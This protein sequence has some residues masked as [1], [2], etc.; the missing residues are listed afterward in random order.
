MKNAV[1]VSAARTP[2][3]K[4]RGSLASVEAYKLGA[5][6]VSEVIK[7]AN[8]KPEVIDEV[9]FGNL[10]SHDVNNMARMVSLEAGLPIETPAL[11]IDRQCG[12]SLN[13]IALGAMMI[14]AGEA[15]AIIAGGVE[16]DSRRPYVML[17][18]EIPYA[19][20]TP[21]F[22]EELRLS[23]EKIGN[24]NMGMTAE[25]LAV[26]Y[27]I[28]REACDRFSINSHKKAAKAVEEGYF[29]EQIVPV[30]V[31]LGKGKRFVFEH[32]EPLRK[33]AS[34]EAMSRLKTVFKEDG[35][36]TAGNSSPMSDGAGA[37]IMME[38]ELAKSL[39][40][41][42][43]A[44]YRGFASA[45][46]DPNIMGI[47]PVPA[48]R[49]LLEKTKVALDDIDLIEMNEAFAAQSLA[50]IS[51]LNINQEKLNVNGGAI[52]L[53]H[54]LAGTGAILATKMV[55]EMKR[56]EA[57]LGLITFCCGGGQGVAMLLERD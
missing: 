49:K 31:D 4:C 32:D 16:S 44:R 33:D 29:K 26:K 28:S 19:V 24:P 50:C 36:V 45:G 7:R 53:G 10:M 5:L 21:R 30:E 34:I 38:E 40:L 37:V 6:V 14:Q 52:A 39:G 2:V 41:E 57:K 22:C 15:K 55:Y 54:P 48:T 42:I 18:P 1:I 3:G 51:E 8:I 27:N 46:C 11:E 17:K 47:G 13:A 23:P 25:N 12:T 9:I 35:V 20:Q 56:R 43:L